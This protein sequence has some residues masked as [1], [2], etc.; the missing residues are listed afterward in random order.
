[1]K[2]HYED[3]DVKIRIKLQGD[4]GNLLANA[5]VILKTISYGYLHLKGFSIWRSPKLNSRLQ[6]SV[7][8]TPPQY[9]NFGWKDI[10]WCEDS[11]KWYELESRIYD[12]FCNAR[13]KSE[14]KIKN[15]DIDPDAIPL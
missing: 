4:K 14:N 2:Y 12:A 11:E 9:R 15:E 6:E 10:I 3:G 8:I 13:L 1:M 7:N 5:L